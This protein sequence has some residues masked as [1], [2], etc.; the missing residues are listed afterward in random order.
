[1]CRYFTGETGQLL[2][3][4]PSS[5]LS[6]NYYNEMHLS[7]VDPNVIM[8]LNAALKRTHASMKT[9][10]SNMVNTHNTAHRRSYSQRVQR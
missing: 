1:M 7:S 4:K 8:P 10:S 6:H 2:T 5:D 3:T 9:N